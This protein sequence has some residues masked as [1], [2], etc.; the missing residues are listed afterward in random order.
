MSKPSD[1]ATRMKSYEAAALSDRLM[2][3]LPVLARLDGKTFH[4]WTKGLHR[5]WD[6]G[7]TYLMW[8]TTR[9][10]VEET[11]AL[12]GYTQSDEITLLWN[13]RL[14]PDDG[15]Y[16]TGTVFMDGRPAKMLSVLASLATGY[17]NQ[18]VPIYVP[19]KSGHLALFDARVWVVPD[20]TETVNAFLWRVQDAVRNSIQMLGRAHF[21]HKQLH[22]LSGAQIQ[23]RLFQERGINWNDCLQWQKEGAF[24]QRK[25]VTV[26]QRFTPEEIAKLPEKHHAR[27]NPDLVTTM[28]RIEILD[29]IP[30]FRKIANK[31]DFLFSGAA[32]LE[33]A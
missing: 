29:G 31:V 20:K 3:R 7:L 26:A 19:L 28:T 10:L 18:H 15:T 8:N 23:E 33:G 6:P 11:G 12:V 30:P 24:A 13:P 21:S 1:L 5:P 27:T 17:F 32:P 25:V 4:T 9:F 14:E 22:G 2:P 16:G